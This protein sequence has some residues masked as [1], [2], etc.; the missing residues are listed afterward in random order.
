MENNFFV[1]LLCFV[2]FISYCHT[3]WLYC[4]FIYLIFMSFT[5]CIVLW[6]SPFKLTLLWHF[7]YQLNKWITNSAITC[8]GKNKHW[9]EEK[10]MIKQSLISLIR[11][12][13][14]VPSAFFFRWS[15]SYTRSGALGDVLPIDRN[16]SS[17]QPG[18]TYTKIQIW[19][20]NYKQTS[21]H[22]PTCR[23]ATVS[24]FDARNTS[25]IHGQIGEPFPCNTFDRR[26]VIQTAK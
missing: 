5:F 4:T 15:W 20:T 6:Y 25:K 18:H 1:V 12:R 17:Y 11:A 26:S 24:G 8:F 2:L 9:P 16:V 10:N 7:L 21:I 14:H 22:D 23:R 13:N 3:V 19:T